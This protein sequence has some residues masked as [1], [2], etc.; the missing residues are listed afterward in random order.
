MWEFGLFYLRWSR[1]F[2]PAPT[3]KYGSATLV[4]VRLVLLKYCVFDAVHLR[5]L[6]GLQK[7]T[8]SQ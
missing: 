2:T 3:K 8:G 1:T 6:C 4:A 5:I 7:D